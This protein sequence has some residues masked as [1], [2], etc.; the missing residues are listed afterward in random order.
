MKALF[1]KITG[2]PAKIKTGFKEKTKKNLITIVMSILILLFIFTYMFQSIVYII[3]PG[4]AGVFWSLFKGTQV[5]YV[6]SEGINII[7]PVNR[8]YIYNV[9]IQEHART[10]HVL[11]KRGLKVNIHYSVRYAPKYKLLGLLHQRVGPDYL[12]VVILPEIDAVLREVIGT[13]DAEQIW[14]TGREV[15]VEA[16]NQAIEQVE[17][18]YIS[19]DDVLLKEIELPESV[20]KSI[21]FKLEQKHLVEAH[22]FIVEKEKEEAKRKRIEGQ[23][24]R[25]QLKI[26]SEAIPEGEI[27]KW[28]GIQVTQEIAKSNNTKVIII[29]TGE[30]GLPIILNADK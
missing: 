24:I 3:K 21:R 18:R 12:N 10:L 13:M 23:G 26:I 5:D 8:M 19:V 29:G 11:T 25:D 27:L 17:Q 30:E 9:R 1:K 28:Q 4:E 20:A 16:I 6:Y 22:Q 15:I 2:L 14:T 7:L